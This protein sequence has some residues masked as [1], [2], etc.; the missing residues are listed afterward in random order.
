MD[1]HQ[2]KDGLKFALARLGHQ[3]V[4]IIF[5]MNKVALFVDNLDTRDMV[6]QHIN[7]LPC[8]LLLFFTIRSNS[9]I[10]C[11]LWQWIWTDF[12]WLLLSMVREFFISL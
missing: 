10:Q 9:E 12:V 6:H 11:L 7:A 1:L 3:Y 2:T 5:T 8:L 4:V